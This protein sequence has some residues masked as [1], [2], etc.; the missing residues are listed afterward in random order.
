MTRYFSFV[1]LFVATTVNAQW[2][3]VGSAFSGNIY[4]NGGN[5][6]IG[7]A[8]PGAKLELSAAAVASAPG[9]PFLVLRNTHGTA[10]DQYGI[11][12]VSSGFLGSARINAHLDPYGEK[13]RLQFLTGGST[14]LL[15]LTI[16]GAQQVGIGTVAPVTRLQVDGGVGT[17]LIGNI[18]YNVLVRGGADNERGTFLGYSGEGQIGVIG[19]YGQNGNLAFYTN[20]YRV[21]PPATGGWAERVRINDD[22]QLLIGV[23]APPTGSTTADRLIVNGSIYLH[24]GNI[25]AKYRDVAE[26]VDA[27]G[28]LDPGTVVVLDPTATDRVRAATRSYDMTVA[29]V[30]SPQPGIVLGEAAPDR[31]KIATTGRVKIKVDATRPIQ[32][33]DLLTTS[34]IPGTAMRSEPVTI[35]GRSFHQPGTIVGKALEPLANGRGEILVLLTLQ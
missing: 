14:P 13:A 10:F 19:A 8:A 2:Q 11:A 24:A 27:S 32:I 22:G 23:T 35:N 17:S 16:D 7:T 18:S 9:H 26:W 34:D 4:H 33:G 29:G 31:A 20:N 3:P 6:G 12:F 25:N 1:I 5:V 15:A 21:G 30:V 28:T